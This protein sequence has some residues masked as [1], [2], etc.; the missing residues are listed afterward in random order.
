MKEVLKN[1][2]EL[3]VL[4]YYSKVASYLRDFLKGKEIATKTYINPKFFFLRRGSNSPSLLIDDLKAVDEKMLELRKGSLKDV[5]NQL[6]GKQVLVWEYFVPRKLVQLFYATNGEHSG[7]NI[8]RIFIDI[9]KTKDVKAE[10]AQEVA[11]KLIEII[12]K[13]KEFNKLVKYKTFLM[14]TGNSFHI[15]LLLKKQVNKDFYDKYLAYHKNNPLDSF[16]GRWAS[17]IKEKTGINVE[18][19]HEKL[20]SKIIIDPSGTPSGK[21]ARAPFSIHIDER[22]LRIDG[23]AVPVS[24]QQLGDRNLVSKLRRLNPEKVLKNIKNYKKLL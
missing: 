8:E 7:K 6:N 11:K 24:E 13:D 4:G 21:L 23:V 9:D 16:I 10:T 17:L 15:Y 2:G 12:K 1:Y 5:K 20:K 22:A 3:D 18:G 14:W 19:G